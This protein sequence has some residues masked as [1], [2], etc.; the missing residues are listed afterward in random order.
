MGPDFHDKQKITKKISTKVANKDKKYSKPFS[1]TQKKYKKLVLKH[2]VTK[3][4]FH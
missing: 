2:N 4:I 1:D 3:K